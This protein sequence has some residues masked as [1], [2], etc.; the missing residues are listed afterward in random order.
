[1]LD[2]LRAIIMRED[3][4]KG[5]IRNLWEKIG[6]NYR[7]ILYHI[8]YEAGRNA[9]IRHKKTFSGKNERLLAVFQAIFQQ[10]GYG[11]LKWIYVSR[12]EGWA[13]A[14]VEDPFE[15]HLFKDRGGASGHLIRGIL[16][17]WLSE[18]FGRT[19]I[20]KETM[21]VVVGDPYCKYYIK[22]KED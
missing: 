5:L 13:I 6:E 17:G 7:V 2:G 21:C 12:S 9:Y 3:V 22:V 18:F 15:C 16:A 4:Y 8:G 1:M 19:V 11:I 10:V 14:T 20:A